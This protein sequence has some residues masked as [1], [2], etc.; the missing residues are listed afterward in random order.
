MVKVEAI[1][2]AR[3]VLKRGRGVALQHDTQ[4]LSALE[5]IGTCCVCCRP[6]CVSFL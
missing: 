5:S 4:V 6:V 2:I 1:E 3:G